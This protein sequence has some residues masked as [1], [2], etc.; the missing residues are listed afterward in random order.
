MRGNVWRHGLLL[1]SLGTGLFLSPVMTGSAQ[2]ARTTPF[3]AQRFTHATATY[4]ITT[5]SPYYRRVWR[6]AV[7][8]WNK[9]GAFKFRLTSA[10][11]AAIKLSVDSSRSANRYDDDVGVTDY[12]AENNILKSVTCSLNSGLMAAYGYSYND[13]LH[14]AEHELGHAMGLDHNPSKNSVM[15][16]R[17]RNIGIRAVDVNGVKARYRTPAGIAS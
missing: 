16:Y 1:L 9:T 2:V 5:N 3:G 11:T 6:Q 12:R 17:N 15:Y 8:A 14:V 7:T 4:V 10:R 13:R